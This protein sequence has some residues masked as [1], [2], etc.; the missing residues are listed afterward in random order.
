MLKSFV[1]FFLGLVCIYVALA[2]GIF[3]FQKRLIHVPFSSYS[4]TPAD[5]G[6][7]F[8]TLKLEHQSDKALLNAWYLEQPELDKTVLLFGGNA[9]N[10]SY[11]LETIEFFYGLGYSV[12]I[13]DYR[14]FGSSTGKLTERAMYDD[15]E[16]AWRHLTE[17]K[18]IPP[19]R[20]VL[21]GRSLGGAMASWLASKYS[22]GALIMESAFT[23]MMDMASIYYK[24][25]PTNLLVRFRYDNISRIS[26]IQSPTLY[27]HSPDDE[28]T[29]Y[30]FSE[31][32]F[33]A[34]TIEDKSFL[35]I[36]GNHAQGYIES[37]DL[38]AG[39]IDDFLKNYLP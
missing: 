9:G 33:D 8:E 10:M 3:Y 37:G 28:L 2:G 30:K 4:E 34:M 6:L 5:R 7:E 26:Q 21:F 16:I 12:F 29:P 18:K 20:I 31:R 39:G 32:L 1:I 11:M 15:A 38:Y 36:H 22:P 14:T 27:I 24:W 25:L 23:S 35:T 17:T 13:Y 19:D